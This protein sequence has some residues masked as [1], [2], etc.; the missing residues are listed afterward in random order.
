ME[1]ISFPAISATRAATGAFVL[2]LTVS[3][4]AVIFL[5]VYP[6]D[7]R[8]QSIVTGGCEPRPLRA[9]R[10]VGPVASPSPPSP[11]LR[12]LLGVLTVPDAYERRSLV[13][14]AYLLQ[15][16]RLVGKA[17]VDVRFVLCN[18]TKEEQR[19]LVAMEI[20]LYGDIMILNC[21]ENVNDGKTYN[22]FSS[23][24]RTLGGADDRRP[25]DYV[26]KTDDDTYY[27]LGNLAET[28]RTLPREDLYLGLH[29]PCHS[30]EEGFMSGM[31]YLLSWDLVEWISTSELARRKMMGPEDIMVG[32]WMNEAD[33]GRNRVDTNPRM[34]DYP[35]GPDTCYRHAFIPDTIAVHKLKDNMKWAKTLRYFN[36]THNLET[37][38]L[39]PY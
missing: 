20:M 14:R 39:S 27:R 11:D 31:G 5:V 19:V 3:L 8:L 25:Y 34:Y 36:V 18:L 1:R 17:L 37:S 35:E 10:F 30:A 22:Y 32:V 28:L 16:P 7:L 24:P 26:I 29:V 9:P 33:R 2:L 13:R 23:L 15:Q 38:D 12:V 21:T 4:I 6:N